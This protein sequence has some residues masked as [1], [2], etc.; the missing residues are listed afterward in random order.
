MA[1]RLTAEVCRAARALLGNTPREFAARLNVSP[2]AIDRLEAGRSIQA[3]TAR[4]IV[5]ALDSLGVEIS[6]DSATGVRLRHVVFEGLSDEAAET[7]RSL[8]VR[9]TDDFERLVKRRDFMTTF[10]SVVSHGVASEIFA[11]HRDILLARIEAL[12]AKQRGAA[13][14]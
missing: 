9:S 12:A 11:W 14:G 4:R 3:S 7:L 10:T 13:D 6:D 2:G 5:H 8:G 1:V